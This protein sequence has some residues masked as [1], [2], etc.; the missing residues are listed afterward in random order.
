MTLWGGDN[1][2]SHD[3]IFSIEWNRFLK[4][5]GF[6]GTKEAIENTEALSG[7]STQHE[8]IARFCSGKRS[9][10]ETHI[11]LFSKLFGV[12]PEYLSGKDSFRT[13]EDIAL[14]NKKD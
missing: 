5:N 8:T 1:M 11:D 7:F 12:R 3:T 9:L 2:K 14:F 10:S 4:D 6:S 13:D